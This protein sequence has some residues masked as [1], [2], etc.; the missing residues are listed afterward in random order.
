MARIQRA[1]NKDVK[2]LTDGVT[3]RGIDV[4]NMAT[5]FAE[6]ADDNKYKGNFETGYMG[7]VFNG[8]ASAYRIVAE[9]LANEFESALREAS[10]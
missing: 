6:F 4:W 8:K 1:Y 2:R 10:A 5:L 7:G 3:V 9:R